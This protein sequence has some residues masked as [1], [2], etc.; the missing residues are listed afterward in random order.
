MRGI[1]CLAGVLTEEEDHNQGVGQCRS[2]IALPF[3][4]RDGASQM[5]VIRNEQR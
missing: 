4:A 2:K 1:G 3:E 5:M